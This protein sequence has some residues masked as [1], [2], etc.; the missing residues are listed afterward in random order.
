MKNK[1]LALMLAG[2]LAFGSF[3]CLTP[4]EEAKAAIAFLFDKNSPNNM[5]TLKKKKE[6][7][8]GQGS[9]DID[10]SIGGRTSGVKGSWKSSNKNV[11]TVSDEGVVNA[12]K[13]GTAIISFSYKV[14]KKLITIKCKLIVNSGV[15]SLSISGTGKF[16]GTMNTDSIIQFK[17]TAKSGENE[18]KIA[19]GR[20]LTY[21]I[22]YELFADEACTIKTSPL[23]ATITSSGFM[24]A[25]SNMAKVY[26]RA[27][28]KNSRMANDGIHSNVIGVDIKDRLQ[29]PT[30]AAVKEIVVENMEAPLATLSDSGMKAEVRYKLLDQY[31]ND[32]TGDIRFAGKCSALWEGNKPVKLIAD[33]KFLIDL[34]P[35]QTVGYVGKLNITYGGSGSISK[36]VQIKIGSP[37]YIKDIQIM[38]IY[39]RTLT[40]YVKVM[41]SNT[42]L[43]K[44]TVINS[45]GGNSAL[46]TVP[47]SYYVLV[48]AKDN[49]G[50]SIYNA[51]IPQSKISLVISGNVGL[52]LENVDGKIQ[53]MS[54]ITVDGETFLTYPLKA[55]VLSTGNINIRAVTAGNSASHAMDSKVT[56]GGSV[57]S[58]MIAGEGV[59]GKESLISYILTNTSN[60]Q[61]TKYEE[62]ISAL[63]LNDNGAGKVFIM[64][65]SNIIS[66][67]YGSY[68]YIS[69]NISTGLAE[70]Y[71]VPSG[72]A[73]LNGT[74]T[75]IETITVLKGTN[76]QKDYALKVT[77]TK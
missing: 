58:L 14:N 69:K 13:P 71:Y 60:V 51:G 30:Q 41:D 10:Y 26:V 73:L 17:A 21:G 3:V 4:R 20:K 62:V 8:I 66:S 43:T 45:F 29:V 36:E 64:P 49:Y 31:G 46:N 77:R 1:V 6:I 53:T 57:G 5:L 18:V 55:G 7:F 33:G 72:A 61:L 35:N 76:A 16:D 67:N 70:L 47:E 52:A 19:P 25:G 68:F 12:K 50:N 23:I 63:G 15:N 59:V 38:G 42:F 2:T 24:A 11:A 34:E 28:V 9:L 32:V 48:R 74:E 39:K 37:S 56:D 75:N 65:G 40:G 44:G 22:F 27:S 54:P